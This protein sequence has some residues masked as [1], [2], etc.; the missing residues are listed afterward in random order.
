MT[1]E[2][3]GRHGEGITD[4]ATD[5]KAEASG[6]SEFSRRR[7]SGAPSPRTCEPSADDTTVTRWLQHSGASLAFTNTGGR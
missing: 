2:V 4:V 1:S 7:G 5:G 6:L 3:E